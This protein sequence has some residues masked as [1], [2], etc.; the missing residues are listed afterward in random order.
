MFEHPKW[1]T[2]TFGRKHFGHDFDPTLEPKWPIL[3]AFWEFPLAKMCDH[4]LKCGRKYLFEHPEW[5][6]NYFGRKFCFR[7]VQRGRPPVGP[8]FALP[9][10][11]TK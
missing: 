10:C 11:P 8:R 3:S 7:P 6:I 2:I 4:M 9:S 1:C 5:S